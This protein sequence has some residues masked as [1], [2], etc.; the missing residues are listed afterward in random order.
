MGCYC[1]CEL[2]KLVEKKKMRA[3]KTPKSDG[4]I[5][6]YLLPALLITTLMTGCIPLGPRTGGEK[7]VASRVEADNRV[8][9]QIVG[10]PTEHHWMMLVA[11]DGLELNYDLSDTW[12]YYLKDVDGHRQPLPFFKKREH[13][14][15]PWSLMAPISHTNLWVAEIDTGSFSRVEHGHYDCRVIC[16]N[17]KG[18]VT[19][20]TLD[21]PEYGK[22]KFDSENHVLT[23]QMKSGSRRFDPLTHTD[24]H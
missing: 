22:F 20:V 21:Y 18:I 7:V 23:Y 6:L 15:N 12:R 4:N 13:N 3:N 2:E 5:S 17:A 1:I 24:V 8:T 9:E 14:V 11:P 10:V 19:D 16:F